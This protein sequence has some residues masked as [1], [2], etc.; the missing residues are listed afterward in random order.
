MNNF[1]NKK[2]LCE[3]RKSE[4]L[5]KK[6][7]EQFY[8]YEERAKNLLKKIKEYKKEKTKLESDIR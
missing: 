2:K 4:K 3:E 5:S 6:M 7:D 8:K 1:I